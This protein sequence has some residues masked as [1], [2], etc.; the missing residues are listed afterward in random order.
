MILKVLHLQLHNQKIQ[1]KSDEAF[2]ALL[3][4]FIR[5]T[6]MNNENRNE[7]ITQFTANVVGEMTPTLPTKRHHEIGK[8]LIGIIKKFSSFVHDRYGKQETVIVELES[9]E[10]VSAILNGY[11]QEGIVRQDAQVNDFIFIDLLGKEFSKNGNCF[12]K[13]NLVIQKA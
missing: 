12:N 7:K 10:L 13:F 1:L 9:G 4:I 5:V 8:P 2:I 3:T 11:L 6:T